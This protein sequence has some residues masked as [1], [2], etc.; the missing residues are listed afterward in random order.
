M[1]AG[2]E[3]PDV[4]PLVTMPDIAVAVA[5]LAEIWG[6]PGPLSREMLRAL[7]HAGGYTSGAWL[8]D[9]LVGVSAGFLA[10]HDGEL[11]LHSHISGVKPERQGA[12]VGFALKQH[13]RAWARAQGIREIEWTF[14]PLSRRNAY[15]N[16][17][18]LGAAIVGYEPDFYGTMSDAIN[19]GGPS[20]RAIVR[21]DVASTSQP[22]GDDG[23]ATVVL[24]PDEHEDPRVSEPA[25]A[26]L[27]AW[28]PE[29]HVALRTVEPERA[30][31]W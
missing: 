1:G 31:R 16:L 21:W 2:G 20:D 28:I 24:A 7:S 10:R 15:F 3:P 6:E 12:S 22:I 23:S 29:D 27:R 30:L 8:R 26:V 25:G 11:L 4:R 19:A 13:Q 18:K 14:D 5:L 17:G 9:E